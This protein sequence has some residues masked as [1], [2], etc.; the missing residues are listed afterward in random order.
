MQTVTEEGGG[1]AAD[2]WSVGPPYRRNPSV[3]IEKT[4]FALAATPTEKEAEQSC[5]EISVFEGI[6]AIWEPA[7]HPR[8]LQ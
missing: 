5:H 4:R 8:Y 2:G 1:A 6:T 7:G 3:D